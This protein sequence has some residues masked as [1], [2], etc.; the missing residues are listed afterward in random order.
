MLDDNNPKP[1]IF[2]RQTQIHEHADELLRLMEQHEFDTKPVIAIVE[3][4]SRFR[5]RVP[6]IGAFSCGKTTLLNAILPE[7]LLPAAVTP[8][9]SLPVEL[10]YFASE[11][12]LHHKAN[13][14]T[15]PLSREALV[16]QEW[17]EATPNDWIEVAI[18]AP[19]LAAFPH[20]V[21]VDMPGWDSGIA[22]H[23]KAI[24]QYLDRSLAYC[25]LVS[26][27]EGSLQETLHRFLAE[28]AIHNKPY[29]LL[30]T[31]S[32]KKPQAD[33]L[34][35]LD[36]VRDQAVKVMGQAPLAAIEIFRKD[37]RAPIL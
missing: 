2:P 19:T 6:L 18:D 7:P 33:A 35:V 14:T 12:L 25:L 22:Q 24:D 34:A 11:N 5:V 3:Q 32:D 8:E 16:N 28:L 27:D 30:I 23:A 37:T 9:T 36:H 31:K 10:H 15:R 13:D 29:L 1:S 17:P 21:L 20:L 26:V 4:S